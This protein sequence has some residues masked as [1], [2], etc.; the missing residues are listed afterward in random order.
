MDVIILNRTEIKS[1][2]TIGELMIDGQFFCHILEDPVRD[3]NKNGKF[4][5][6]EVK[7]KGNTAIP[8]G[9]YKI[10]MNTVSPRF[11]NASW[12]VPYDGKVPRLIGVNSFEG[13]LIHPGNTTRDTEGCLLPGVKSGSSVIK[14][15]D[16]F[17]K[18]MEKLKSMN[19]SDLWIDIR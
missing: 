9:K 7:I 5:G 3:I 15:Q 12:A 13:V 14:S 17:H 8:Y 16:T 2:Y 19:T 1:T 18:L 10:D 4:D 11:R 6:G